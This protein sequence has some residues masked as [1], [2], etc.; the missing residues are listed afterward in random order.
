MS[1]APV[2]VDHLAFPTRDLEAT[3]HFYSKVMGAR[4]VH[5]E[6]GYSRLGNRTIC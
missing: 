6:S 1:P 3:D 5:A 2:S 4:L